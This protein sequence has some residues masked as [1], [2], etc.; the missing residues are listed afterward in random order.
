MI[1]ADVFF[2]HP[3]K[4]GG[5]AA[6]VLR[7]NQVW[8][9]RQRLREIAPDLADLAFGQKAVGARI[10]RSHSPVSRSISGALSSLPVSF[11]ALPF[12]STYFGG[13]LWNF[14]R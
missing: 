12:I 14:K 10:E 3:H 13:C 11:I 5:Q 1:S 6:Y 4:G 8:G 7:D 2:F 9:T